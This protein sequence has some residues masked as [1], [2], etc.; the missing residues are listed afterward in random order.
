MDSLQASMLA[1]SKEPSATAD[2][3]APMSNLDGEELFFRYEFRFS[4]SL[5]KFIVR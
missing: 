1:G 3:A 4:K 5:E 2:D